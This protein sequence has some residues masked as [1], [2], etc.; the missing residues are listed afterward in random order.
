M[1]VG[2]NNAIGEHVH[3][4]IHRFDLVTVLSF[5]GLCL[6]QTGVSHGL[7]DRSD[8]RFG[9]ME[10]HSGAKIWTIV[11]APDGCCRHR[12]EDHV[13]I[14]TDRECVVRFSFQEGFSCFTTHEHINERG[15]EDVHILELLL[16]F[17]QKVMD[18]HCHRRG[19]TPDV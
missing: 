19:E 16:G 9:G 1:F 11:S 4:G 3:F 6:C 18:V 8:Q 15:L 2:R 17:K 10:D 5:P 12:K 7:C 14:A 13:D